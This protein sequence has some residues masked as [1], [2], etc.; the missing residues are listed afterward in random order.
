MLLVCHLVG[1]FVLQTEWQALNKYGGLGSDPNRR[2]ALLSHVA[3]YL[4][5]VLPALVWI[6]HD[7]GAGLAI[8]AGAIIAVEHTTQDDGRLLAIYVHR[9]K[10]TDAAPGSQLWMAVDQSL[11]VVWLFA[12]ALLVSTG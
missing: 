8:L 9:V 5:P 11:H 12:I 6:G 7:H 2:A 10:K 4:L 1:D 3:T